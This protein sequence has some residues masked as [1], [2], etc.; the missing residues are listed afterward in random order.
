MGN[1]FAAGMSNVPTAPLVSPPISAVGVPS[2]PVAVTEQTAPVQEGT[3]EDTG[4]GTFE[5]LHKKCK[6]NSDHHRHS[7]IR[8]STNRHP[9]PVIVGVCNLKSHG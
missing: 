6:G 4:P 8:N 7:N 1:V 5:E 2:P 3:S 9:T